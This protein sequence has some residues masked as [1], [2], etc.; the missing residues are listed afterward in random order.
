[1]LTLS[2]G[3]GLRRDEEVPGDIYRWQL[4]GGSHL[5]H[6]SAHSQ[7]WLLVP[8]AG[9]VQTEGKQE[10]APGQEGKLRGRRGG[11][12]VTALFL[13]LVARGLHGPGAAPAVSSGQTD[14]WGG[15]V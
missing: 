1:M 15:T 3:L 2:A 9:L 14:L 7:A 6:L 8:W 10:R 12:G 11:R 13:R 5:A 4:G